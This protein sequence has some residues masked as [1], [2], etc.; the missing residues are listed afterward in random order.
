MP[1]YLSG[2][3]TV[4]GLQTV[5]IRS[6]VDGELIK[7]AFKE[8]QMV[9]AGDLLAEIDPRAFQVQLRQTEGQLLRD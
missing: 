4:T 9:Q 8:G 5:T 7:V 2:L 1:V 3:G 6:R